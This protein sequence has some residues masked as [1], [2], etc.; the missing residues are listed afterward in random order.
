MMEIMNLLAHG[1]KDRLVLDSG[2]VRWV[3][4]MIVGE[5]VIQV[6]KIIR[7]VTVFMISASFIAAIP[8][9]AY[10]ASNPFADVPASHWAYD[11]IASL[12][13]RGVISGYP[14]GL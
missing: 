6:R 7:A 8:I 3:D 11:S 12:A 13:S 4:V 1:G 2:T 9:S 10:A 5:V 14:E